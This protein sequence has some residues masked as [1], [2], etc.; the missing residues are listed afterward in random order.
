MRKE[1]GLQ[2]GPTVGGASACPAVAVILA[3]RAGVVAAF[4][5]TRLNRYL[6][7]SRKG[8]KNPDNLRHPR[9]L[10]AKLQFVIAQLAARPTKLDARARLLAIFSVSHSY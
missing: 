2:F 7:Q 4:V 10:R 8:A 6:T 3:S 5:R 1:R 9:V